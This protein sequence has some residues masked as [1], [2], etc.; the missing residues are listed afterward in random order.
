M[1][2]TKERQSLTCSLGNIFCRKFIFSTSV[3]GTPLHPFNR[4]SNRSAQQESLSAL[5]KPVANH[6]DWRARPNEQTNSACQ[7]AVAALVASQQRA[8]PI[9]FFQFTSTAAKRVNACGNAQDFTPNCQSTPQRQR[10]AAGRAGDRRPLRCRWR[11]PMLRCVLAAQ[12]T[13]R[14]RQQARRSTRRWTIFQT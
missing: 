6:A 14:M 11:R 8:Q 13:T 12:T 1:G 2:I 10:S 9:V 7:R 4:L 5:L 3:D